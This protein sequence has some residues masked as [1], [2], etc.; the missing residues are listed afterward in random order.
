M[1]R[2]HTLL[3]LSAALAFAVLPLQGQQQGA[4]RQ[5]GQ[6]PATADPYANNPAAGT[7]K[8]PLAAPAGKDSGAIDQGPSSACS[9]WGSGGCN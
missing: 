4:P 8:F 9:L 6:E 2:R 3:V 1:N 7:M 5:G